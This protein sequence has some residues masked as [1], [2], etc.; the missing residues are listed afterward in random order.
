M[1]LMIRT[2]VLYCFCL[3]AGA[4]AQNDNVLLFA[5]FRGNGEDGLH[6]AYS[7]DALNWQ[8]L[9]QDKSF[10][11][12]AVGTRLMRDPTLILGP[13][14]QFH[15]VWTSG[16]EDNGIGIAHSSDLIHWSPQQ[17]VPVM[18]RFPTAKNAWAPEITWDSEAGHYLIYWA[19][20][21]PGRYPES[22]KQA[23]K[24]WDHRIYATTTKDFT[25]YS[26]TALFY[27]PDFNV[28]DATLTQADEQ[29]VMV[30]KDETR[31]PP[32][33]NLYVAM[34]KHPDGPW[35]L[36]SAA[37]SPPGVW[38]EGPTVVA[39]KGGYYIYFDKYTEHAFGVMR[40]RDFKTFEDL[41]SSLSMPAGIRHGS[42]LV[43]PR[44][45]LSSLL[46]ISAHPVQ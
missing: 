27:Q 37:F 6:L 38:V 42:V 32:A 43:I 7:E 18:E 11:T 40:T 23:D 4:F 31:Y 29:W 21:L 19:S 39:W 9:N 20:T 13:D 24:G 1:R 15:M 16:W 30:L 12:P 2:F 41:S 45:I 46:K 22:E 26:P 25:Q 44:H 34:A 17:F 5:S 14:K 36:Q 35:Q 28:I 3:N 8:A 10:L 33:K